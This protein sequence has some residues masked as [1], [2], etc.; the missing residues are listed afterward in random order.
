MGSITRTFANNILS[1]GVFDA[2]DLDGAIPASNIA[3]ASVTN[4]TAVPALVATTTVASDPPSPDAGQIW[5]NSTDRVLRGYRGIGSWSSG[6]TLNTGRQ[7]PFLFGTQTAAILS[8]GYGTATSTATESY[9]GS[10]WTSVNNANNARN[11]TVRGGA[12]TQTA[13][14]VATGDASS[15]SP[16]DT[17]YTESWDGTNWTEVNDLN[18]GRLGFG[19]MCGIQTAAIGFSGTRAALSFADTPAVEQWDGTSWTEVGDVNT[20]RCCGNGSG[21]TSS[22]L[23]AGGHNGPA[24][25][26]ANVES[27]NGTAWTETTDMT[28]KRRLGGGSSDSASSM[29]VFAG[30]TGQPESLSTKTEEWNG[31]SWSE[32][33]DSATSVGNEGGTGSS[34]SA[35]MAG[36]NSSK[37]ATEEFSLANVT[38]TLGAS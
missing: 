31:T 28:N 35:L 36:G 23:F 16:R 8:H 21:T 22:A 33:N 2:T 7:S 4:I 20:A 17:S 24:T 34:T 12:G 26:Y 19:G 25:N 5:Y 30:Y 10:A 11:A 37:T 14:L 6:G 13:G 9:N 38:V 27:W 1:G 32:L 15:S 29:I 3:D 18:T